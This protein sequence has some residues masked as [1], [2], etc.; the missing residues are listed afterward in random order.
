VAT[1]IVSSFT[2]RADN[3]RGVRGVTI[4]RAIA[5]SE[6]VEIAYVEF[7]GSKPAEELLAEPRIRLRPLHA[8]R[9]VGRG[10][11]YARARLSRIPSAYAR[12]ISPELRHAAA[13]LDGFDRVIAEGPVAAAALFPVEQK[14]PFIYNGANIESGFRGGFRT[15][16]RRAYGSQEQ[17]ESF[18]RRLFRTFVESWLPTHRDV[19]A[20]TELAP[21]ARFRYVPNVVDVAAIEP[22]TLGRTGSALFVADQSYEPNAEAAQFLVA[23]VMPLVWRSRPEATLTLVGR[24][25]DRWQGRDQRI[26][27]RGFVD[28]LPA[29]YA[30]SSC[31]VVPLL[32]GGG[33]PLKLVEA[34]AYGLPVVAT[35][36]ALRGLDAVVPGRHVAGADGADDFAAALTRALDGDL[37]PLAAEARSLVEREYSVEA[38]VELVR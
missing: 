26:D 20:A 22:V 5:R 23:E 1:L 38:L 2:P 35:S 33:S 32:Q 37:D 19:A 16:R 21:D 29:V 17:H 13:A 3:G 8:S 30:E 11:V 25:A 36:T 14:V 6:D 10:V 4:A 18:E 7:D 27:A 24:H 9:G 28:E 15:V 12:G 34:M 31:A